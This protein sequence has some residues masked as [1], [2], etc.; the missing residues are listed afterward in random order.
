MDIL[1]ICDK[2]RKRGWNVVRDSQKTMGPYAYKNAEWVSFDDIDTIEEK[3]AL[4]RKWNLGKQT[5]SKPYCV[6]HQWCVVDT[7]GDSPETYQD[8]FLAK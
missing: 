4:L 2:V 6:V 1:Q 3:M 8:G 7:A 5:Y